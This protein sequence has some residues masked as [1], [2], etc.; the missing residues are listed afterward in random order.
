MR[1]IAGAL[2]VLLML[3]RPAGAADLNEDL[4]TAAK[5]GDAKCVESLLARG[6]DVNAKTPYGVTALFYAAGKGHLDVVKVLIRRKADIN[7]ADSFYR[8]SPLQQAADNNHVEVVKALLEAGAKGADTIL[9]AAVQAKR[10]PLVRAILEKGKVK[11]QTLNNAFESI[12]RDQAEL[13]A[14]LSKAGAKPPAAPVHLDPQVLKAYAGAYE[15]QGIEFAIVVKDEKLV[16]QFGKQDLYILK[17]TDQT[18]FKV[19]GQST[20]VTFKRDGSKVTGFALNAGGTSSTFKRLESAKAKPSSAPAINDT[21]VVVTSPQNWPS[22]RGAHASGIADGQGPPTVWDA[23]KETNVRWKTSIPGFGHSCPVVWGDRVFVTTAISGD[24]KSTFKP[25]LYGNVDSVDDTTVH[26]WRVYCVD[27]R[28][29]KIV[30]ERLAHEGVP[31]IKRHTKG[32]HA[33]CTPATDGTHLVVCFGSEGLY[34]YDFDGNVLWRRDLGVLDSGFFF[35]A[36]YQWGFGSSPI[37]YRNL[38]IVQCDVGKNSYIAAY[39]VADGRQVWLTPRAEIPSWGTPTICDSKAGV[40][41]VTNGTKFVRGYDPLTGKELWRLG[42][43]AEITVPT[44]IAGC[45]LVFATSGYRPIQPIYAIRHGATG[46]ITLKEGEQSNR[47]VAWSKKRNGPYMPTPIVY[48]DH[49]YTCSNNGIVTCY[50]AKTGKQIYQERLGG[51]GGYTASPVAAD[52]KL[53][54]TSEE[55]GIRVVK[56]GPKFEILAVNPMGDVCMA[57]PAISDGML[58]VR[59]QHFLYAIGRPEP[60]KAAR[61]LKRSGA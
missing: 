5:K 50:E 56:A 60:A 53:Y 49:L 13:A 15:S 48:E 24:P 51:S 36:D 26:T 9:P 14:L 40:E 58:F 42:R 39:D 33:N 59:T 18:N 55:S 32:S 6:A 4:W 22:F 10:L 38:V 47:S 52:G 31:K 46:D 27:K 1:T 19:T 37:I 12:D 57:T 35:D 2:A 17:P 11:Q 3:P 29:G 30:W 61:P 21:P 20:T 41:L 8:E 44:P 16:L 25:G 23:S 45:G 43:N 34:C 28:S 54:F 7:A